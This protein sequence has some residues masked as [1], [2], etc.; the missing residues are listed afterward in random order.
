LELP[1]AY[2]FC[3]AHTGYNI[4][5]IGLFQSGRSSENAVTITG[6]D[7]LPWYLF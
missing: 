6:S 2:E 3:S 7:F 5:P 4:V 1:V